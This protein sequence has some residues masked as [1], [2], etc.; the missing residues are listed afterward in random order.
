MAG[1]ASTDWTDQEE[2]QVSVLEEEILNSLNDSTKCTWTGIK[3]RSTPIALC[4][5]YF[6]VDNTPDKAE[7]AKALQQELI[8][9][10]AEIQNRYHNILVLGDFNSKSK[11]YRHCN[12]KTT[13]GKLLDNVVNVTDLIKIN[14]SEKCQGRI[15][16]SR[17]TQ[18]CN[19]DYALC[20]SKLY[21]II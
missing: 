4:V 6:P 12:Q 2:G 5:T 19:I 17:G 18:N 11:L 15:T 8:Q 20:T 3:C 10:I 21:N 7:D 16:W 13:N 9:N 1:L 14:A